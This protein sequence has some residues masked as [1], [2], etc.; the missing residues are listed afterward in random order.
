MTEATQTQRLAG[1]RRGASHRTPMHPDTSCLVVS[2]LGAITLSR[3]PAPPR[4]PRA[5]DPSPRPPNPGTTTGS[6]GP[7]LRSSTSSRVDLGDGSSD[8]AGDSGQRTAPMLLH[9]RPRPPSRF[10]SST[11]SVASASLR[12]AVVRALHLARDPTAM[13]DSTGSTVSHGPSIRLKE[14]I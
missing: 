7:R 12:R 3:A 6:C 5:G 2:R 4:R 14:A 10:C 8:D 1:H 13:V 9:R 11:R